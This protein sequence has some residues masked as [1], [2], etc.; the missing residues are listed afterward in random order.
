[1]HVGVGVCMVHVQYS[2]HSPGS[3]S[4]YLILE[5]GEMVLVGGRKH[6]LNTYILKDVL[7]AFK[8]IPVSAIN[9]TFFPSPGP[10]PC[11]V[12]LLG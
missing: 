4:Q 12:L 7:Q 11:L 2:V 9:I 10:Q 8:L 3:K 5:A 6:L 1:M